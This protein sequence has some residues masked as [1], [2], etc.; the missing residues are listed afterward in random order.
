MKITKA[1]LQQ[2]ILE[3]YIKEEALEEAL[4]PQQVEEM[5]AWIRK[6]GPKPDWLGAE[7]GHS[8]K[9]AHAP[10]DPNVDR[11]AET[12]NIKDSRKILAHPTKHTQGHGPQMARK[13]RMYKIGLS[14]L[15]KRCRQKKC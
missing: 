7:Y 9:G 15:F 3:E 1:Q 6:E 10:A 5:L 2:I 4:S 8:K 14:A 11:S 13:K 12:M